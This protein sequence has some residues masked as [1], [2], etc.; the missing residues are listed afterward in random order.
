VGKRK[1]EWSKRDPLHFWQSLAFTLRSEDLTCIAVASFVDALGQNNLYIASNNPM[2]PDHQK[3]LTE[4]LGMFLD[5]KPVEEIAAKVLPS[6]LPYIVKQ[7]RK[8]LPFVDDFL[9][10]FPGELASTVQALSIKIIAD[11]T[12]SLDGIRPLM[13]LIEDNREELRAMKDGTKGTSEAAKKMVYHLCKINRIFDEI[14]FV[15]KK[16]RKHQPDPA[17]RSLSR[18]FQFI[19]LGCHAELAILNTAKNCCTSRTLYIGVSK[20]PCYC[21][22]LFF[23]AVNENSSTAFNISIVTTHGK[24]YGRWSKIEG[25]FEKEFNQVWT[26]VIEDMTARGKHPEQ[27]TDDNSSESDDDYRPKIKP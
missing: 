18:H 8:G 22:S 27:Q 20:R 5:L 13:H 14:Y 9:E 6:H 21:C 4:I 16:N 19:S 7:F 10:Y 25:C 12:L 3:E 17:L 26:K 1:I 11:R 15:W 2:A 23:K 24:L